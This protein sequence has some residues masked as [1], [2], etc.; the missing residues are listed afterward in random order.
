MLTVKCIRSL[1]APHD[2]LSELR[3]SRM[4][5]APFGIYFAACGSGSLS[6][7]ATDTAGKMLGEAK[8]SSISAPHTIY[9]L[10]HGTEAHARV[11]KLRLM[12]GSRLLAETAIPRSWAAPAGAPVGP[13]KEGKSWPRPLLVT[14]APKSG[15]TWTQ[16]ILA[17]HPDIV[18]MHEAHMLNIPDALLNGVRLRSTL[19]DFDHGFM[20]ARP[21]TVET[22]DILSFC[23]V[24]A[25][26]MFWS[27]LAEIWDCKVLADRTP[28][29]YAPAYSQL[30]Q[31]W[32]EAKVM[33]LSR[34]PLDV[35]VS[36]IFHE[37]SILRNKGS[38][39]EGPD[40]PTEVLEQINGTIEAGADNDVIR[41]ILSSSA[42]KLRPVIEKWVQTEVGF[43]RLGTSNPRSCLRVFYADLLLN[44]TS[45]A[46]AMFH[47]LD[48][49]PDDTFIYAIQ[50][51]T[52]F[53]RLSGGRRAG[54]E[55][56]RSFYRKGVAG[57]YRIYLDED[58]QRALWGVAAPFAEGLGYKLS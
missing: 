57:D 19:F 56:R 20:Q 16:H 6:L 53:A 36:L 11:A 30:A 28:G 1:P 8:L 52:T 4:M 42:V 23:Q 22:K 44:F 32:P 26:R 49:D 21:S 39:F 40:I 13:M 55:D 5:L 29:Y 46:R 37:A 34:H 41:K 58:A 31:Y 18:V 3:V 12:R 17:A 47:F 9:G 54:T 25:G 48:L 50:K 7:V 10:L 2:R 38:F 45:T 43:L 24:A 15:T 14:G 35:L 27:C 33:H 51:K